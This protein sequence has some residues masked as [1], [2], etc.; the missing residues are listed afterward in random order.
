[1]ALTPSPANW[2]YFSTQLMARFHAAYQ[3]TPTFRALISSEIPMSGDQ[4]GFS[5]IGK[6][7][8]LRLWEG[9]RLVHSIAPQTYFVQLGN[10]FELTIGVNVD[11]L[12]DD[13]YGVY[14]P[15][16]AQHGAQNAKWADLELRDLLFNLGAQT[17]N[18]QLSLDGLTHWNTAHPVDLYN[19]AAGTYSNDF[20]GGFTVDG[21]NV[22]GAL[23]IEAF[24][25][26]WAEMGNRKGE[27]GESLN[28]MPNLCVSSTFLKASFAVI[29]KSQTISPAQFSGLGT[30][31]IG[32][33]NGPFVGAMDSP[34]KGWTDYEVIQDFGVNSTSKKQWFMLDTSGPDKP[35]SFLMNQA[36]TI[37]QRT[38]ATDPVVFDSNQVL[39]GSKARGKPAWGNIFK[40]SRSGPA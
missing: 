10:P 39:Y 32:T 6:V 25:T 18:A 1:M 5:W 22:G 16:F 17:G 26:L 27:D 34:I 23:S 15:I 11:R 7:P 38:A 30:G 4:M 3:T 13:M 40:S 9:P 29:L 36:P 21:V 33:S 19:A 12:A 28:V 14:M 2:S 35:F 37:T 31:A 24:N 20:L 8:R